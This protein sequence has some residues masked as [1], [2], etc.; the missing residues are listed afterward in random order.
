VRG[1]LPTG[2]GEARGGE[3]E[4]LDCLF[5]EIIAGERPS[6]TVFQDEL[7]YAFEDLH[8]QA[9]T[10][11]L[12]VPKRHIA[13]LAEMT[14]ADEGLVGHLHWVAKEV[15]RNRGIEAGGYRTVINTN[16]GAGQTVF[17]LHLHLLGGKAFKEKGIRGEEGA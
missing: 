15:A 8:P 6:R 16:R 13:S 17:H 1:F 12:V 10:H 3:E 11:V 2:E 9:P 7:A 4:A 14:V 5:C